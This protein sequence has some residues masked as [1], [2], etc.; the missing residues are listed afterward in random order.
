MKNL[1]GILSVCTLL[2]ISTNCMAF[3][4]NDMP[5]CDA[6]NTIKNVKTLAD[7]VVGPQFY[8]V[9]INQQYGT[10]GDTFDDF[11]KN[12]AQNPF[13]PADRDYKMM[14]DIIHKYG[15]GLAEKYNNLMNYSIVDVRPMEISKDLKKVACKANASFQSISRKLD[16]VYTV[17]TVGEGEYIEI[18]GGLQ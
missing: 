9:L 5:K 6:T 13:K 14:D 18:I 4:G 17:Q 15:D 10:F 12:G 1:F 16:F 2:T 3:F 7:R 11:K 8:G